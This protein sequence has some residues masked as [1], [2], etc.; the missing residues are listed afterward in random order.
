MTCKLLNISHEEYS[1][2][3][4]RERNGN[5]FY[6]SSKKNNLSDDTDIVW[7]SLKAVKDTLMERENKTQIA[8]LVSNDSKPVCME[9]MTKLTNT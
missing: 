4:K 5:T 6:K 3:L 8:I 9:I 2:K 1:P 7:R